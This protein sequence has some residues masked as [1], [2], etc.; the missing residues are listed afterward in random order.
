MK[1]DERNLFFEF[2]FESDFIRNNV[3]HFL[4]CDPSDCLLLDPCNEWNIYQL[5]RI[6]S[7]CV[8]LPNTSSPNGWQCNR[9]FRS[10]ASLRTRPAHQSR[11][12][13]SL[14]LS[15][16][17]HRRMMGGGSNLSTHKDNWNVETHHRETQ[18]R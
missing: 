1:L 11:L 9:R 4:A 2:C 5:E 17:G 18:R 7:A 16:L 10:R 12:Q 6:P 13:R 14:P 8:V 3:F 15:N